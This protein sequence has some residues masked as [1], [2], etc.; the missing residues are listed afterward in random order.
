MQQYVWEWVE[1][2]AVMHR[3]ASTM[4]LL[5]NKFID[6]SRREGI[7]LRGITESC[8]NRMESGDG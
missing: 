6:I 4:T 8:I 1:L 7:I 3:L 5:L 2:D